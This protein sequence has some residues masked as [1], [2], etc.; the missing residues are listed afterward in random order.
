MFPCWKSV[1]VTLRA[2]PSEAGVPAWGEGEG[3]SSSSRQRCRDSS[4]N[5]RAALGLTHF[6]CRQQVGAMHRDVSD[7]FQSETAL[8]IVH[9]SAFSR[10]GKAKDAEV[11]VDAVLADHVPVQHP[12][13]TV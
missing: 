7:T 6:L 3:N 8:K 1:R 5:G 12:S 9:A 11:A 2:H 10:K 13:R 4:W